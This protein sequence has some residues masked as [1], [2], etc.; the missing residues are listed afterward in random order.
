[1][2]GPLLIIL[3]STICLCVEA[4]LSVTITSDAGSVVCVNTTITLTC[5]AI[6]ATNFKWTTGDHSEVTDNNTDAI[7]VTAT[8]EATEYTCTASDDNGNTGRSSITVASNDTIPILNEFNFN[9]YEIVYAGGS[10]NLTVE[11]SPD[12]LTFKWYRFHA[13]LPPGGRRSIIN[14]SV[15]GKNYS[16]LILSNMIPDDWGLYIFTATGHC[17]TSS[18]NVTLKFDL[19]IPCFNDSVPILSITHNQ[20]TI[21]GGEM[22]TF[23]CLFG[24]NYLPDTEVLYSIYWK[25]VSHNEV[26]YV[27]GN[28]EQIGYI[29]TKPSQNCPPNNY[30][31]CQFISYLH[32]N[33]SITSIPDEIAMTCNGIVNE[34]DSSS[35]TSSLNIIE[36]PRL[37]AGPHDTTVNSH[38]TAHMTCI[39]TTSEIP[40]LSICAWSNEDGRINPSDRYQIKQ[41]P[42]P[43]RDN[44]MACTITVSNV[45][46]IDEGRFC[47]YCYYNESFWK[48]FHVPEHTNINSPCGEAKLQLVKGSN[49]ETSKIIGISVG[50]IVGA[51]FVVIILTVVSVIV[52]RNIRI[53]WFRRN[54]HTIN[55]SGHGSSGT[56]CTDNNDQANNESASA[57]IES[58]MGTGQQNSNQNYGS[59]ISNNEE[60]IDLSTSNRGYR[61]DG[62]SISQNGD[63]NGGDSVERD[64]AYQVANESEHHAE[65]VVSSYADVD[66]STY[67]TTECF[68]STDPGDLDHHVKIIEQPQDHAIQ[69][70]EK[71]FTVTLCCY[72]ESP[73]GHQLTYNWYNKDANERPDRSIGCNPILEI[74]MSLSTKGGRFYCTVSAGVYTVPS[75]VAMVKLETV[76]IVEEPKHVTRIFAG[77]SL[78]LS[79]KAES[80]PGMEVTY[81]WFK[82]NKDGDVEELVEKCLDS[83]IIMSKATNFNQGYYKCVI[84]PEVSSR[85]AYVEVMTPTDIKFTTH[86][87]K[88]QCIE[89]GNEL[90]LTCEAECENYPITYQWYCNKERLINAN[91]SQL[92]IPQVGKEDIGSYYCEASSE[93]SGEVIPSEKSQVQLSSNIPLHVLQLIA[94]KT[95]G[96][97]TDKMALLIGNSNYKGTANHLKCPHNDV[98]AMAEKLQDLGFKTLT[99]VD[100]SL[101]EMSRAIDY[102]CGLLH[103][104]MYTVFYYSGHGLDVHK[105]TYLIPVDANGQ[106]VNTEEC[107]NYDFVRQKMQQQRTKVIV[108]LDCCRTMGSA[109]VELLA[110]GNTSTAY[111]SVANFYQICACAPSCEAFE[112]EGEKLSFMTQALLKALNSPGHR[113]KI[114][115]KICPLI[116]KYYRER[117]LSSSDDKP[118]ARPWTLN[119][120]AEDISLEDPIYG[121][122][123]DDAETGMKDL[124]LELPKNVEL[125]FNHPTM[126]LYYRCI[127]LAFQA[128]F[129]NS[130]IVYVTFGGTK[131]PDLELNTQELETL[132]LTVSKNTETSFRIGNLLALKDAVQSSGIP[133]HLQFSFKMPHNITVTDKIEYELPSTLI[134]LTF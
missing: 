35:S 65:Q 111:D 4:L 91:N 70:K 106:Q 17:G 115:G 76:W 20:T 2:T 127:R 54:Y 41:A 27:D 121:P 81:L 74:P 66:Q 37:I 120:L 86:P 39:F 78:E 38:E 44:R 6:G 52:Y 105:T 22:I 12:V 3:V 18:V 87:P 129:S 109:A 110:S 58:S 80:S 88:K 107:V 102:F 48:E 49:D 97:A 29:V 84:S 104:G 15:N 14:Y 34:Y 55:S 16:S 131:L 72:A 96:H 93:Y 1:M 99:L 122:P 42:V 9:E 53:W 10:I 50:S 75:R 60:I 26:I 8:P 112:I 46:R 125:Y 117:N 100:V 51:V 132:G 36:P 130:L 116:M 89:L 113:K 124:L 21:R 103:E 118:Y 30:S 25:I 94:E 23:E 59:I 45:T 67:P 7:T 31:C 69:V 47:C 32:I 95:V 5:N 68:H 133:F 71:E 13:P 101:Q 40:Y 24:G 19:D 79:C 83:K 28:S 11:Y 73:R 77:D 119:Q 56:A 90:T 57:G 64:G 128:E 43:G 108:F 63:D 61:I 114:N 85:V 62:P 134:N 82:C 33:T 98:K 92:V 126:T 123:S